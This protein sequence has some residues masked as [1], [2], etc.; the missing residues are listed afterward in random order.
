M[1]MRPPTK[2]RGFRTFIGILTISILLAVGSSFWQSGEQW[3]SDQVIGAALFG[4][5]FVRFWGG[6]VEWRR[7]SD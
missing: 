7:L 3:D 5:A 4:L 1:D 2:R 6:I